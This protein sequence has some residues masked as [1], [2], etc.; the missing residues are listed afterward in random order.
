MP[1]A[2]VAEVSREF[3]TPLYV[4]NTLHRDGAGNCYVERGPLTKKRDHA[5]KRIHTGIPEAGQVLGISCWSRALNR[6]LAG[7][8]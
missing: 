4:W 5:G 6:S 7:V 1:Y 2:V 8:R 3:G